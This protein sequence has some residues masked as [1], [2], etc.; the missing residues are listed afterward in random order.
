MN[1]I[2]TISREFGSIMAKN[3][4]SVTKMLVLCNSFDDGINTITCE[5][6]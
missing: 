4:R 3:N 6:G 5:L 2:I 1:R